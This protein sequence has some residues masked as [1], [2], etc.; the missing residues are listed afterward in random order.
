MILNY[1]EENYDH[2]IS[3]NPAMAIIP[4]KHDLHP[5]ELYY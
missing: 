3:V 4:L 2:V 1:I 5:N